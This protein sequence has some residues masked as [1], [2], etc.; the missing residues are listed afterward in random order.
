MIVILFITVCV[1][2]AIWLTYAPPAGNKRLPK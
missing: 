1:A 2:G